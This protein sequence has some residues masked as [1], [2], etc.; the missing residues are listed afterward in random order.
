[1]TSRHVVEEAPQHDGNVNIRLN[2]A[3]GPTEW[4]KL[5][6][7][8]WVRHEDSSIDVAIAPYPYDHDE[9]IKRG[10]APLA[11][12]ACLRDDQFEEFGIAPGIDLFFPGLFVRNPGDS[13]NIPIIRTGTIAAIPD[14]KTRTATG[15]AHVYLA[16]MR[17]IG[18]HSGSPVFVHFNMQHRWVRHTTKAEPENP[19][20]LLGVVQGHFQLR[21]DEFTASTPTSARRYGEDFNSG[22]AIIVPAKEILNVLNQKPLVDLRAAQVPRITAMRGGT[23]PD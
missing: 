17:S 21:P 3:T 5:P 2:S 8:I 1:V 6:E 7:T 11:S 9:H 18:G 13:K 20:V 4:L 23:V 16:E 19:L 12:S 10:H 22:I 15:A 14:E